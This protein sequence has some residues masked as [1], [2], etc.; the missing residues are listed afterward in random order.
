LA[1]QSL[2]QIEDVKSTRAQAQQQARLCLPDTN[3]YDC[4]TISFS[5]ESAPSSVS[6]ND[7]IINTLSAPLMRA[8]G[9]PAALQTLEYSPNDACPRPSTTL[10]NRSL[11]GSLNTEESKQ[12]NSINNCK[13]SS[14]VDEVGVPR[15]TKDVDMPARNQCETQL[16]GEPRAKLP[17]SPYVLGYVNATSSPTLI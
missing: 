16:W 9:A 10:C 12:T 1:Q 8:E 15:R 13:V 4:P 6:L 2:L 7:N 5:E 3:V 17:F 11:S 14:G